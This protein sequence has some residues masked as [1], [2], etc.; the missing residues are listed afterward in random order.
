MN[1]SNP[2][3]LPFIWGLTAFL[4]GL[5]ITFI[6][7]FGVRQEQKILA[8]TA[9][10][11][12]IHR[13]ANETI[14]R[15]GLYEYGLRG[16]RGFALGA[17]E[18]LNRES[19]KRY[20]ITRNYKVEFP[21]ARGFGLA[22]RVPVEK[23]DEFLRKARQ[24]FMPDFS[25]KQL[26]PNRQERYVIQY[27]EPV[28]GNQP[29]IGLDMGSEINR[30][31]AA[32]AAIVTGEVQ[33]TAPITLVQA[34]GKPHQSFLL[35]LPIYKEWATPVTEKERWQKAI[36]WGYA[37]L[38]M[39]EILSGL[40]INGQKFNLKLT[41]VGDANNPVLFYQLSEHSDDPVE[42]QIAPQEIIRKV[43]GRLW[44]FELEA[45][46]ALI[47]S[48][49]I[50]KADDVYLLG[51]I[52]SC[53]LGLIAAFM[54]NNRRIK[55]K[56]AAQQ[57]ALAAIVESSSDGII[58]KTLD[59]V[60]I[61]W[62]K[63][64][65]EIFGH[66]EKEALGKTVSDLLIPEKLKAE[67]VEILQKIRRGES[68]KQFVT[69][70]LTRD[71]RSIDVLVN[72]API[73][74]AEGKVISASKTVRD[75]TEL[76][77]IERHIMELNL[78]LEA[79]VRER[80]R[81]LDE[82][83]HNL[84]VLL[85]A[86]PSV[87]SY[88]DSQFVNRFANHAHL[89]RFG[90]SVEQ[91]RGKTFSHIV[92]HKMFTDLLPYIEL[93]LDGHPQKLEY[94]QIINHRDHHFLIQILPD[95]H[96]EK[97]HGFYLIEYDITEQVESRAKLTTAL[98]EQ[99][100]LLDTINTQYF[101]SVTD[102][103]G[104]IIEVNQHFCE[105]M[106]YTRDELLGQD[107]RLIN[108]GVHP[109]QFWQDM[110]VKLKKGSVWRAEVC[111]KSKQ[112][113]LRW[114]ESVIAPMMDE[115]GRIEKIIAL[116]ND[117]TDRKQAETHR[118]QLNQLIENI[119]SAATEVSIIATDLEGRITLFNRGAEIMLGYKAVDIVNEKKL[120]FM[121][122]RDEI[123]TRQEEISDGYGELIENF[124]VLI[125]RA[126][127]GQSE[128]RRWTYL[129]KNGQPIQVLLTVTGRRDTQGMLIGYLA[130]AVDISEQL[131]LENELRMEKENAEA[132]NIAKSQFL[133]NMSHEIR[134]PMNAVL[135]M[136]QLIQRTALTDTQQDY[137][138][139]AKSSAQS[140]LGILND[141]LDFSKIEA[142]KLVLDP[143]AFDFDELLQELAVIMSASYKNKNVELIFD[144]PNDLPMQ[145]VADRLRLHQVLVNLVGNALKF[146]A[147]GSVIVSIQRLE[148]T[149]NTISMR[150]SVQDTGIGINEEQQKKIFS[151]F[152]QAEA[153]TTRRY[154]GTG[155]GLVI[156]KRLVKLMKSDLYLS[157]APGKGSLFWFDLDMPIYNSNLAL[158][159]KT[160]EHRPR[161]LLLDDN[162]MVQKIHSTALSWISDHIDSAT[163]IKQAVELITNASQHSQ[164]YDLV[165]IDWL[166]SD[167]EGI[168]LIRNI[169]NSHDFAKMPAFIL[170][171]SYDQEIFQKINA[172]E[173]NLL[174]NMLVKPVT[175]RQLVGVAQQVLYGTHQIISDK[176]QPPLSL[177]GIN[178]L[179]IE[180]NELNRQV[181]YE[182]LTAI[183]AKVDLADGGIEGVRKATEKSGDYDLII[184]D[185]QMPDI[186]GFEATYL[187]KQHPDY[188]GTPILAMTANASESDRQ[189]CLA[190]GM[191]EH[192]GKPFD[193]FVLTQLIL[194]LT[195]K[196]PDTFITNSIKPDTPSSHLLE[197]FDALVN[198]YAGNI[199]LF[200]RFQK[201]FKPDVEELLSRLAIAVKDNNLAG[202]ASCL[203]S[204]KGLAA[205][206]GALALSRYAGDL[207]KFVKQDNFISVQQTEKINQ[208]LIESNSQMEMMIMTFS[209]LRD[210]SHE[211]IVATPLQE[212]LQKMK[213][214]L[215]AANMEALSLL[216]IIADQLPDSAI[217][218]ELIT[219]TNNLDF[220]NALVCVD[221]LIE[222]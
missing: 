62:N 60:I 24:D 73:T 10:S 184:M 179:V 170:F 11:L 116:R 30:R 193:L 218:M 183:G 37:P 91:I 12:E 156:C 19:F 23:E 103:S 79:K 214:Y 2:L 53:L 95:N 211:P 98:R 84:E 46:P 126:E 18:G 138:S 120:D 54:G 55:Q 36:G 70:R 146:T 43:S 202:A 147:A 1:S 194:Q 141:I 221:Q 220:D 158:G 177:A 212:N 61:S 111:N 41:D 215:Q 180:D 105:V 134:T 190:A 201:K 114:F 67:E 100:S 83:R 164:P 157:S 119:L 144:L 161:I 132:A 181:A 110:W 197:D 7:A 107:H 32:E 81:E 64:A 154:G 136:I 51:T 129:H 38:L 68:I 15:V 173:R 195:G 163:T 222:D 82:A 113:Q 152:T 69:Q 9:L 150:I 112:G 148:Q 206:L 104:T 34:S 186:D 78:T 77:S 121:H 28:E 44:R 8:E 213:E 198:R 40:G 159:R 199:E 86:V 108:S 149:K 115:D 182:L 106:G 71:G 59:G 204:I 26:T 35:L 127:T 33:L 94:M 58:G 27:V 131:K 4:S 188:S 122:L 133:A 29:A 49:V 172:G 118:N 200:K 42:I 140:L 155:L 99:Q 25:I 66:T 101:Y 97:I 139:K 209:Q 65:Q 174:A 48:M 160:A 166:L 75:I 143:I 50:I 14:Q 52:I 145:I 63:G 21:G 130:I 90:F 39:E 76:K 31:R 88:W 192:T 89:S 57:S 178:L 196:M 210:E 128:T 6:V 3:R 96:H 165:F 85:D 187:I 205:T 74:D 191:N 20:S 137:I 153:S 17:A 5:V 47:A 125:H 16:V 203:H 80:T 93:A 13:L 45:K 169:S 151:G 171:A 123:Q 135:G 92:G 167:G 207:E 56:I 162:P 176:Q 216:D 217:K 219:A 87:I 185:I 168:D 117:I 142:D 175:P 109:K 189:D 22:W 102:L 208:L 72:V 124:R